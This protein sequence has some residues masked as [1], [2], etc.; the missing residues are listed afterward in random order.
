[1]RA[2]G[3]VG[4]YVRAC[5]CAGVCERAARAPCGVGPIRRNIKAGSGEELERPK[6]QLE[7]GES[8]EE[9]NRTVSITEVEKW[10]E[11]RESEGER[12]G[13]REREKVRESER[14]SAIRTDV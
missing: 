2:G 13:A 14:E 5:A 4:G 3:W 9:E 12:E 11:R 8:E 6:E 7:T 10:L 1:M